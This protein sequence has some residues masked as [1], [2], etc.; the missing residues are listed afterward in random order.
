MENLETLELAG[1][2]P[3]NGLLIPRPEGTEKTM[4]FI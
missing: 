3:E 4:T 1:H 2:A